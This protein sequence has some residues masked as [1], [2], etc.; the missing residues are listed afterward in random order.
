MTKNHY[1]TVV[2]QRPMRGGLP[3]RSGDPASS[4]ARVISI[5]QSASLERIPIANRFRALLAGQVQ[6]SHP[7]EPAL[8]PH[9]G[10]R[11][12]DS[13]SPGPWARL[14]FGDPV[15][16]VSRD[17]LLPTVEAALGFPGDDHRFS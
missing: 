13:P 2:A 4:N 3:V 6:A 14:G 12:P 16:D 5:G 9:R 15:A 10:E 7:I 11:F 8:M 17:P 1:S